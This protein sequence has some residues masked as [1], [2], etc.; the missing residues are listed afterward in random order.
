M[1]FHN[2][3]FDSTGPTVA[4][5]VTT[6]ASTGLQV[7]S[8]AAMPAEQY[9]VHNAGTTT[10]FVSFGTTALEASGNAVIPTGSGSNAKRSLPVPAGM[11]EVISAPRDCYFSTIIGTGT[12]TVYVTPGKGN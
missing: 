9:R 12:A 3:A 5:S 7:P 8:V 2:R 6:S 4:I 10:V 11:V 1:G